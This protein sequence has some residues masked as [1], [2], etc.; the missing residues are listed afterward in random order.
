M[1]YMCNC[2]N[3]P[4]GFAATSHFLEL[5]VDQLMEIIDIGRMT[6]STVVRWLEHKPGERKKHFTR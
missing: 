4:E 1:C 5:S 2:Q 6:L 3:N